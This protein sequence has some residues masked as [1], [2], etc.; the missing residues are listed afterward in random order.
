MNLFPVLS[1]PSRKS[2]TAASVLALLLSALCAGTAAAET[3]HRISVLDFEVQSDNPQYK[4]LGK[5]FAEFIGIELSK[6]KGMALIDREK[7]EETF[8]EQAFTLS[9]AVDQKDSVQLGKMLAADYLVTG[10]IF[11]LLGNLTVTF[12]V[13]DTATGGIVFED[14]VTD[15]LTKYDYI[16]SKC[17]EKI[18]KHF[19]ANAPVLIA[20]DIEKPAEAA[21]KFSKAVDAYDKKDFTAAKTELAEA[22]KLDPQNTA[23]NVYI[24]KLYTSTTKFK[25][26]PEFYTSYENPAYLGLL[27]KDKAYFNISSSKP[28]TDIV[29][30][31]PEDGVREE[32]M[33]FGGGY[34]APLA[35][36]WGLGIEF[37]G[38]NTQDA[39]LGWQGYA[40]YRGQGGKHFPIISNDNVTT[41][42]PILSTGFKL[43]GNVALGADIALM[44]KSRRYYIQN[45]LVDGTPNSHNTGN[46]YVDAPGQTAAAF[47]GGLLVKNGANTV[48]LDSY[49]TQTA[50]KGEYF[51]TV[52][53]VFV[54][55][56]MPSVL[57]NTLTFALNQKRTFLVLKQTSYS[58][59]DL[60]SSLVKFLPALEQR[61]GGAVSL[62]GGAEFTSMKL[63]GKKS[64]GAGFTAGLTATFKKDW[65]VDFNWSVRNRPSR[66]LSDLTIKENVIFLTISRAG[67]FSRG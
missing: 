61:L 10:K 12:K 44:S 65:D 60:D 62:R 16:S 11:D 18:V 54:D 53:G 14:K 4:Y 15:K 42:G 19:D 39:V 8:K 5:G 13:L 7:R 6:S 33:R 48:F 28:K 46:R 32:A 41:G 64:S 56:K 27:A 63:N 23:V 58:Y 57:E 47:T 43:S 26:M 25:V 37:A 17:V 38:F 59:S 30:R 35:K 24:N 2:L 1:L 52:A 36:G 3:A 50:E 29:L 9:G 34:F 66:N 51:D 40:P 55:Y 31:S 45:F 20:R 67:L 49:Y 22:K 21:I